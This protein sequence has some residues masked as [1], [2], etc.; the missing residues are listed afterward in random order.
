MSVEGHEA[1]RDE[2]LNSSNSLGKNAPL[3]K[4]EAQAIIPGFDGPREFGRL[5]LLKAIARGGMGEV[6]LAAM[7]DIEGAERPC[8]VK[9]IRKEHR[10][11]ASFLAR[12]LDEA[13]IQAQMQ[14]PGVAQIL[15][16]ALDQEGQPYVVVEH[17]P[18]RDLAEVRQRAAQ[19]K[20]QISWSDA[21]ALVASIADALA[22]VHER[23]DPEGRPL[24]VVHRDL[25]P[26]NIM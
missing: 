8:V 10:G 23:T 22:H 21:V 17:V 14:H 20:L 4:R 7:G 24:E 15:E 3:G 1:G 11:D 16:A 18:G 12:F 6:Y 25:S 13:R 19:L 5:L 26:Q 2:E 9:L